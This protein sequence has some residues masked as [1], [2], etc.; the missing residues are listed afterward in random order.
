MK[1]TSMASKTLTSLLLLWLFLYTY[2]IL[3]CVSL[4]LMKLNEAPSRPPKTPRITTGKSSYAQYL[5]WPSLMSKMMKPPPPKN[6]QSSSPA[7][8]FISALMVT[9]TTAVVK[10]VRQVSWGLQK[11]AAS[12]MA[13][14]TP[15]TGA[16][17]AAATP[18]HAPH[19]TR[20][21]LSLSLLNSWN[22]FGDR[23]KREDPPWESSAAMQ[24]PVWTRGP[25]FPT[26][27]P[28]ATLPTLPTTLPISVRRRRMPG[29]SMPLR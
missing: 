18:A 16:L 4:P 29:K 15:P 23:W 12:S 2:L 26:A 28:P 21:L 1:A 11:L 13:K 17:K 19:V 5:D 10:K 25:S 8:V 3:N 27:R 14:R 7:H 24:L 22:H 20:S 9:L 6:P